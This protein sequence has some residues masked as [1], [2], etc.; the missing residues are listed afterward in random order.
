V[1][2]ERIPGYH[3]TVCGGQEERAGSATEGE[4]GEEIPGRKAAARAARRMRWRKLRAGWSAG[5]ASV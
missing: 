5:R 2:R 1:G 4:N 3:G